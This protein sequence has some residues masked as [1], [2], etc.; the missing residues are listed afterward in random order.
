[1]TNPAAANEDLVNSLLAAAR[2]HAEQGAVRQADQSFQ[3]VL[4][5]APDQFEALHFL[6]MRA[7]AEGHVVVAKRLLERAVEQDGSDIQLLKN[8]GVACIGAERLDEARFAFD[9]A[10]TLAP[11]FFV[12]R[13][14]LGYV[15]E[16]LGHKDA[17]LR[18]YFSAVVAAQAKGRWLSPETTAPPLR[19]LVT[20]AMRFVDAGRKELFS[21]VLAPLRERHGSDALQRVEHC[22]DIYLLIAPANHQNPLQKPKFLYY[23]DLPTTAYFAPDLF[24][25]YGELERNTAVIRE[26]LL[27]VLNAEQGIEPFLNFDSPEDVPKFLGAGP[28]GP[29]AWDAFFF[30][31][32]GVRYDENHALCPR[33]SAILEALPLVRIRAHAPEICFSVLA[34]GTHILP[35]HGVTNT[36]VVTHLPLIVPDDCA[37]RVGGEEHAW[38]EGRCVTFDD[39]FEHEAWNRSEQTRVVLILDIWNPHL[40][41]VE[42]EAITTLVE[43]IGDFN[44]EC[45]IFETR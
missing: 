14:Y 43:A 31:R 45:G 1:M 26:E 38:K 37:I 19:E 42:R 34:P 21:A 39:T 29:P 20:R 41:A 23:P 33:T 25:W 44:R 8:F 28:Q 16:L 6:G 13:V 2:Q 12:A 11:D 35:H 3:R 7:L 18:A 24:D 15:L 4:D 32:H 30:Y 9:R 36:R 17:A 22:L 5:I 10:L 27:A 40:T